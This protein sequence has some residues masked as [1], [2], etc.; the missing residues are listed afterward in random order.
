MRS[1][2]RR[3]TFLNDLAPFLEVP[4]QLV[5][6]DESGFNTAMTR[7]YSR[8]PSHLCAVGQVARNHGLNQTL[9]CGLRLAGPVAP[10]VIPG[11]GQ[12]TSGY[13]FLPLRGNAG[14]G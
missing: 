5:F 6:L 11:Q 4:S 1:E 2:E 3:T 10:L 9:I 8:A 7:L 12:L 13:S 14:M